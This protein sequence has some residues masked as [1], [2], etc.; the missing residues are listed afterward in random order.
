M[1]IDEKQVNVLSRYQKTKTGYKIIHSD[2]HTMVC[3]FK[4]KAPVL[5]PN[6]RHEFIN[7]LDEDSKKLYKLYTSNETLI[8]C[9][10]SNVKNPTK[11]WFKEFKNILQRSFKKIRSG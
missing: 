10:K 9:F 3:D 8:N 1:L 4:I 11:K 2:H 6:L 5:N 7:Y